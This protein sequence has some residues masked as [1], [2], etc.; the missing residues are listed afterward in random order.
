VVQY[1]VRYCLVV[2]G[3]NIDQWLLLFLCMKEKIDVSKSAKHTHTHIYTALHFEILIMHGLT[4]AVVF[5]FLQTA[6]SII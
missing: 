1:G 5:F 6:T 4:K 3:N 2:A